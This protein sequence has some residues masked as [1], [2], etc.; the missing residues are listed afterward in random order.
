M[1]AELC[2]LRVV[3]AKTPENNPTKIPHHK[4]WLRHPRCRIINT[5]LLGVSYY[6]CQV[7]VIYRRTTR[8]R[9]GIFANCRIFK[10]LSW[11]LSLPYYYKAYPM[12]KNSALVMDP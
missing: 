4:P 3:A 6:H 10:E 7:R 11:P 8:T 12:P 1:I 2:Y 5:K 9:Q